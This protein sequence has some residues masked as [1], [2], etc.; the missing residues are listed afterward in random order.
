MKQEKLKKYSLSEY[1]ESEIIELKKEL[2]ER[3]KD[4]IFMS[5]EKKHQISLMIF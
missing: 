4:I 3:I 5:C 1:T 2:S